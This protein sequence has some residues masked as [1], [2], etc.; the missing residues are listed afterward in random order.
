MR[1]E[2]GITA[3]PLCWPAGHRRTPP[4]D[5]KNAPFKMGDERAKNEM[6]NEIRLLGGRN[7][8]VS[9]NV[10]VRQD[11]LPYAD[12]ARRKINDAGVAVYFDLKGAQKC[13]A[14][15]RWGRVS[16]NI[17][18]I[19]LS[20]AALRGLDRWGSSDMVER[21]FTGFAALPPPIVTAPPKRSWR[22]VFDFP[23]D[24]IIGW[25]PLV[26]E[27]YKA[28]AMKR[29]PDNGGSHEAMTELNAAYDEAKREFGI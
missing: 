21:A 28:L 14:C 2:Q 26:P 23:H 19:G 13:F 8:I 7:I 20:I 5:T 6:M 11:G 1:N 4:R 16:E 10:A 3:Y 15:D 24:Q 29:H 12:A 18:A 9:S 17:R 27:R 22:E 25:V